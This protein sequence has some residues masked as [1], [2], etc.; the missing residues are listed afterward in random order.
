LSTVPILDVVRD[1]LERVEST[2]QA[3]SRL[4]YPIVADFLSDLFRSGGKRL[5]P[6][7]VFLAGHFGTYDADRLVHLATAVEMLHTA[8]LVHDDLIDNSLLR[9]GNP[10]MNSLWHG[11]VVV[12]VGDYLF[13]TAADLA[14]MANDV[15]TG[16][17]FAHTLA[18]ICNGEL[19]Q[20]FTPRSS[21]Q[22]EAEYYRKIYAKTASL[23]AASAEVGAILTGQPLED[24]AKLR[25]YGHNLGMAFQV[26]DDVLDF[27]GQESE[28]GKPVGSDL[29]QG[30]LTLPA[31]FF[32]QEH[33]ADPRIRQLLEGGRQEEDVASQ[34]IRAIQ[35]S[36]AIQRSYGVARDFAQ[37]ARDALDG[38]PDSEYH[39][40]MI[41]LADYVVERDK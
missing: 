28:L 18:I 29:R 11:G 15:P 6:A 37:K 31:I 19:R 41:A 2:L 32:A 16:K 34:L 4:D 10:T 23:F 1:D 14:S 38:F 26:I 40:A 12:L 36:P 20:A 39:R 25:E 13:A 24:Q 27:V 9:R 3:V 8:T 7:L 35:E 22:T 17:L 5:R 30:T 21:Q 33:T